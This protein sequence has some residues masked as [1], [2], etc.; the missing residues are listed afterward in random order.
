[1]DPKFGLFE[2]YNGKE[3]LKY[4]KIL[5]LNVYSIQEHI[6]FYSNMSR[7]KLKHCLF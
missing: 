7:F 1:V 3:S 5:T 4:L 6:T 2:M